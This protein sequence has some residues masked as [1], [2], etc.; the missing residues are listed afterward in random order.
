[1]TNKRYPSKYSNGKMISAS[2][3]ISELICEKKAKFDN[4]DL[5]YRFWTNKE[6]STFYKNQIATANKLL[7]DYTDTAIIKALN[8]SK[9]FKI[10][11]LR[12]PYLVPIIKDEEKKLAQENKKLTKEL[13]RKAEVRFNKSISTKN[14]LS[15]L[16]DL[17]DGN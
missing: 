12:S 15:K 14:I 5:G 6:W 8:H 17:E 2:Q 4:K 3:Y 7:K 1:M 11:S 13:E 9:A 10:Y 16:K